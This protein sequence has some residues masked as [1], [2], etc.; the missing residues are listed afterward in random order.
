MISKRGI[1]QLR[2]SFGSIFLLFPMKVAAGDPWPSALSDNPGLRWPKPIYILDGYVFKSCF[3]A[4]TINRFLI[5]NGRTKCWSNLTLKVF[6]LYIYNNTLF[7]IYTQRKNYKNCRKL[8]K[9]GSK[10]TIE[11]IFTL[12]PEKSVTLLFILFL[13]QH[14]KVTDENYICQND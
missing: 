6:F 11:I 4:E 5:K 12:I 13:T 14:S 9:K 8:E 1:V 2:S 7:H 10:I 3:S